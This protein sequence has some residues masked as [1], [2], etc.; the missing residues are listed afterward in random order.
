MDLGGSFESLSKVCQG[1]VICSPL[2]I[3][4]VICGG[5]FFIKEEK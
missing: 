3:S 4:A 2:I 5:S 1:L